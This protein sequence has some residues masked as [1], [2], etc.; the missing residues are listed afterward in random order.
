VPDSG[1][2]LF[3]NTYRARALANLDWLDHGFGTRSFNAP[4]PLT[5]LRQIHSDIVVYADRDGCLGEGDALLSDTPGRLIGVKTAD[6][7][8]ILLVDERHRTV[9]AVHAGWR[10]A[11]TGVVQSTLKAMIARCNS[12]GEGLHAAIGPGIGPCCFEVGPEV[13]ILFGKPLKRTRIDLAHAIRRQLIAFGVDPERIYS[14]GL[15]TYCD[16]ARFH[17]F[18]RDGQKAGRLISVIGLK[19]TTGARLI[20]RP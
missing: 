7:L 20:S 8:P 18:R 6:C 5:T 4:Q 19:N 1:F 3:E 11:V 9:A 14:L 10:G 12:D 17:S 16:A 2:E 15:C 13:A